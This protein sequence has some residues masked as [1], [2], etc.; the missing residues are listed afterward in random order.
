[1]QLWSKWGIPILLAVAI[2]L[3][4]VGILNVSN[5]FPFQTYFF[6]TITIMFVGTGVALI[7]QGYRLI[8]KM[9]RVQAITSLLGGAALISLAT[10]FLRGAMK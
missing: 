1:M 9:Q 4:I 10:T 3:F 5:S 8:K 6:L 7:L 2:G